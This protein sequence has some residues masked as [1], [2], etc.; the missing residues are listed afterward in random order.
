MPQTGSWGTPFAE[1]ESFARSGLAGASHTPQLGVHGLA[2]DSAISGSSEAAP[3]GFGS[4][5][6]RIQNDSNHIPRLD[7]LDKTA[8]SDRA[9]NDFTEFGFRQ[10]FQSFRGFVE[11]LQQHQQLGH[12]LI[13]DLQVGIG[14][15]FAGYTVEPHV[16]NGGMKKQRIYFVHRCLSDFLRLGDSDLL[17]TGSPIR[18]LITSPHAPV[19][20][21]FTSESRRKDDGRLS[22]REGILR[23]KF[24][25]AVMFQRR[26]IE[27]NEQSGNFRSSN[28]ICALARGGGA[29][30]TGAAPAR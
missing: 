14:I 3:S 28:C 10:F 27:Q 15:N 6:D 30:D 17:H 11:L 29:L 12:P 23:L 24:S 1:A 7:R 16:F 13:V 2:S 18:R 25:Y 8:H 22:Q 21:T 5:F 9:G 4:Y 19:V 20:S 26:A